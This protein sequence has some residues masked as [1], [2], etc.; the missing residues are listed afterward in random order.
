MFS[1][2]PPTASRSRIRA[3]GATSRSGRRDRSS[4]S[5]N[6][7]R[8]A[9]LLSLAFSPDGR[10]ICTGGADALLRLW[11]TATG[12]ELWRSPRRTNPDDCYIRT[13]AFSA[14]G[15]KVAWGGDDQ[16]VRVWDVQEGRELLSFV[17]IRTE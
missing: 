16:T 2:S 6:S 5:A 8:P 15:R 12:K 9:I 3:M 13:V 17:A 14:D 7:Q 11:T 1:S 4:L 10:V